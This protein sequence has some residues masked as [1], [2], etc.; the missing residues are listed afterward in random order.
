MLSASRRK[1]TGGALATDVVFSGDVRPLK[2]FKASLRLKPGSQP[3]FSK[4]RPAP[5]ALKGAIDRVLDRL[6][7]LGILGKVAHSQW[8]SPVVPVPKADGHLPMCGDYKAMLNPGLEVDQISSCST[9]R[10]FC[11]SGRWEE[12]P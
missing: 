11:D 6:E 9:E 3:K 7:D 12:I 5:F 10:T 8:A 2:R 4:A 1:A